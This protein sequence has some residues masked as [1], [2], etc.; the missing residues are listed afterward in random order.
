MDPL[1]CE[2]IDELIVQV[3]KEE[4]DMTS[5]VISH[6]MKAALTTAD[7]IIMLYKG[8]VA[9]QGSPAEFKNTDNPVV[10]QFFAG[11]VD[12]PMKLI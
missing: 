11:R 9:L 12:G 5:V 8:Q 3:N 10:Q 7:E 6:D 2:M 4:Q 1:V